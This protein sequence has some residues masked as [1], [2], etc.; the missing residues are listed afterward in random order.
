MVAYWPKSKELT[1]L[2][3][4]FLFFVLI[5][6]VVANTKLPH[7]YGFFFWPK[8]IF[9]RIVCKENFYFAL[10]LKDALLGSV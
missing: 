4:L 2:S 1:V 10:K 8:Q 6:D 5:D 9:G 3:S 7:N